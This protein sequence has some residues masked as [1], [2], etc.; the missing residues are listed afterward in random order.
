MIEFITQTY[1]RLIE[2]LSVKTHR[3]LF[4]DFKINNRL[5]GLIGPRGVGKTTLLLQY[6]KEYLYQD[7]KA[8]YFSAD[9]M[10]LN[11][12]SLLQFV[13]TLYQNEG[14]R[15]FFIDEI[16]KY[17][18]W[19]QELKNL[20]DAFPNIKI[21]FSGSSMMHLLDGAYDLS[22]RAT[23]YKLNGMSFREYLNITRNEEHSSLTLESILTDGKTHGKK[24]GRIEK[25]FPLFQE[26]LKIGYYPFFFEDAHSYYEKIIRVI[27]KTIFEDIANF[28]KLKTPNLH[29][30][31]KLL[32][33]LAS[34]KPGEINTQNLSKYLEIDHKTTFHYLEILSTVGLTRFLD[35]IGGGGQRVRKPAKI[36]LHNTTLMHA[37]SCYLGHSCEKGTVRE[38]F[39]IQSMIDGSNRLF[40]S[41]KGDYC[42]EKI[43]FE[44]G[45]KSK[46]KKQIQD[47]E[48]AYLVKDDI[49][50][51]TAKELPLV[52]F[53][54]LY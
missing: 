30:F 12:H 40:Y 15:Y 51:Q 22:R 44:I 9:N 38:L 7:G 43:V 14:Y 16:H 18:N 46:T 26:Y 41:Q 24:I 34:I 25:I 11:Q 54:F 32:S 52:Y 2:E 36:F 8:F 50:I 21:I 29:I 3:Y 5:T 42:T 19:N 27:D 20:Y 23:I 4:K 35:P 39:F 48:N 10:Y 13:T 49:L 31:K 33:Y 47:I 17:L 37:L 53:G 28:Y 6:I 1:H 45:G